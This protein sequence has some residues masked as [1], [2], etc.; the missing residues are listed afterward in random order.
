ME[1]KAKIHKRG[2]DYHIQVLD[3]SN[4][5]AFGPDENYSPATMLYRICYKSLM[6]EGVTL[7]QGKCSYYSTEYCEA[8][9]APEIKKIARRQFIRIFSKYV[10]TDFTNF[11]MLLHAKSK[12]ELKKLENTMLLDMEEFFTFQ[13]LAEEL[14]YSVQRKYFNNAQK[15]HVP[16]RQMLEALK[17]I[18]GDIPDDNIA[19]KKAAKKIISMRNTRTLRGTFRY[20]VKSNDLF[21]TVAT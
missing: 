11:L 8:F 21:L 16:S 14:G 19:A 10:K 6:L 17:A 13:F 1:K 2:R 15:Q 4:C 5:V 7:M 9:L 20:R 12:K 3:E 18:D